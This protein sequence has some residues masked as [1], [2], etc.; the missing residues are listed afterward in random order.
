MLMQAS[1]EAMRL[2]AMGGLEKRRSNPLRDWPGAPSGERSNLP[3]RLTTQRHAVSR[4]KGDL[5]YRRL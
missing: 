4:L 1:S 5:Q 3:L 2:R